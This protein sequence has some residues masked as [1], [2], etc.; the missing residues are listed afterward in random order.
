MLTDNDLD[1]LCD[2][3]DRKHKI[4]TIKNHTIYI[5][6][7]NLLDGH[8]INTALTY[9]DINIPKGGVKTVICNLALHYIIHTKVKLQN[10]VNY[11]DSILATDG[12]FIF[13]AFNKD[14]VLNLFN[15]SEFF[16][17]L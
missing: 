5:K 7:L 6:R 12:I 2:V 13:T 11:L 4:K 14:S 16:I 9:Q 8:K 17:F 15:E 3:I 10:F 1:A